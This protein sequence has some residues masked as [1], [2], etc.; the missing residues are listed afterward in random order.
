M[1]VRSLIGAIF[2]GFLSQ[3][4]LPPE[5]SLEKKTKNLTT[6]V[7]FLNSFIVEGTEKFYC[8]HRGEQVYYKQ[9]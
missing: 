8:R 7:E 3:L 5:I 4:E 6:M 2:P 1:I 9:F